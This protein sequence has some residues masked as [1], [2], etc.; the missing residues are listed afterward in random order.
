MSFAIS[1]FASTTF[2]CLMTQRIVRKSMKICVV[3]SC[4]FCQVESST[5]RILSSVKRFLDV[6]GMVKDG[7]KYKMIL[8]FLVRVLNDIGKLSLCVS[9]RFS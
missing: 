1:L 5:V 2:E 9:L 7:T 4:T 6:P 8:D 3:A